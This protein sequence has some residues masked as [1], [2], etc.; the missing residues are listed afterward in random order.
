MLAAV[1]CLLIGFLGGLLTFRVKS[2]WCQH[3]GSRT[4]V[5]APVQP[6]E[7]GRRRV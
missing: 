6:F 3:C 2:R 4:A 5:A 1:F 7:E